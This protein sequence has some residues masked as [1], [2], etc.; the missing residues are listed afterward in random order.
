M[1]LFLKKEVLRTKLSPLVIGLIAAVV[2]SVGFVTS[3]AILAPQRLAEAAITATDVICD[4]CIGTTDLANNA[5]TSAKIG[6]G[7]VHNSDIGSS[8]VTSAK[9]ADGTIVSSDMA[10]QAIISTKIADSAVTSSKLAGGAVKPNVHIVRG[11]AV[12]LAPGDI[13]TA[14]VSCQAAEVL[15]GGGFDSYPD[16]NVYRSYPQDADTWILYAKSTG[17]SSLP[18]VPYALCIGPSP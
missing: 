13:K 7:Q 6:N 5:V 9:I 1:T 15:S 3:L 2:V 4:G 16:V 17:G 14:T 18:L 12:W 10:D 8:A 11:G